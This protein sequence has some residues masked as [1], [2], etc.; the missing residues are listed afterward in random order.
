MARANIGG[1]G[2][3][4]TN[5]L[6]DRDFFLWTQEQAAARLAELTAAAAG[7]KVA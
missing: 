3:P 1:A 6:Y 2:M 7:K 4:K 5:E